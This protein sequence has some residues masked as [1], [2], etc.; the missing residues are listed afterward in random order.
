MVSGRIQMIQ[1]D[2]DGTRHIIVDIAFNGRYNK[3]LT[4]A[5][6]KQGVKDLL[7]YPIS[8]F[9]PVWICTL[10]LRMHNQLAKH[11]RLYTGVED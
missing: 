10:L 4:R 3:G 9:G 11:G 5:Q 1:D 7:E 2:E 8:Q 6:I